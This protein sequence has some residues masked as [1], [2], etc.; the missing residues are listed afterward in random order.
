MCCS[1][2]RLIRSSLSPSNSV[3]WRRTLSR[4]KD[5]SAGRHFGQHGEHPE[6]V[7]VGVQV[8][9]SAAIGEEP[10]R[11]I[12]I[13]GV[14]DRMLDRELGREADHIEPPDPALAEQGIEAGVA[15]AAIA[16][17]RHG[18]LAFARLE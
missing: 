18:D 6:R 9:R 14:A 16:G 2:W 5:D 12:K 3:H 10:Y 15:E 7:P 8:G 17:A 11:P 13:S 1:L 4:R